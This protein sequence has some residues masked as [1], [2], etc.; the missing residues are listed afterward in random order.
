VVFLF[1]GLGLLSFCHCTTE[2]RFKGNDQAQ[3]CCY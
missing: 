3:P 1:F 2:L